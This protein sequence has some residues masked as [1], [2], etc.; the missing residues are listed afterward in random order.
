MDYDAMTSEERKACLDDITV[1][2]PKFVEAFLFIKR[3]HGNYRPTKKGNCK[4]LIGV[5]GAGIL[6]AREICRP[7]SE[8]NRRWKG[9]S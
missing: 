5:T 4:F 2:H 7:V 3:H 6:S 9:H 8:R 1:T